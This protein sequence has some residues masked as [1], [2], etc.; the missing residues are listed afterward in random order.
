MSIRKS[1]C[2]WFTNMTNTTFLIV[3]SANSDRL[4][5]IPTAE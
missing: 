1:V 2:S 4:K 5:E 3:A